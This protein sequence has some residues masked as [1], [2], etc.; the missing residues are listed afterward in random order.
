[1]D[2]AKL[3]GLGISHIVNVAAGQVENYHPDSFVY[4]SF[5]I[6]DS[7]D[8]NI[9]PIF[10]PA[11]NFIKRCRKMKARVLVHCIAG[12]SRSSSVV[13]AYLIQEEGWDLFTAYKHAQ[14]NRFIVKPN[15]TFRLQLAEFEVSCTG[16]TTVAET[17]LSDWNFSR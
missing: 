12:V 13:L 7:K 4:Q 14:D 17:K 5:D 2:K 10:N 8:A 15:E 9:K 16:Y 3:K 6:M 11:I 1:M